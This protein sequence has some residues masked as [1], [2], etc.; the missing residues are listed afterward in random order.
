M[1]DWL[2]RTTLPGSVVGIMLTR[3]VCRA[4]VPVGPPPWHPLNNR[5]AATSVRVSEGRPRAS[6][7]IKPSFEI[8][9]TSVGLGALIQS[10]NDEG[11]RASLTNLTND[12]RRVISLA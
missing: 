7:D 10:Q 5:T 2:S 8:S 4:G 12:C 6:I 9:Y 11:V 3:S 1:S